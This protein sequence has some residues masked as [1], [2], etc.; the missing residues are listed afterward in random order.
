MQI[1]MLGSAVENMQAASKLLSKA[2]SKDISLD[3][4]RRLQNC[5]NNVNAVI[6][7]VQLMIDDMQN[8]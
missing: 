4:R 2:I 7:N 3:Q 1:T 6:V 8:T 5:L